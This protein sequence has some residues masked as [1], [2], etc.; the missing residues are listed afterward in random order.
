MPG[1]MLSLWPSR[2][3]TP[4][5]GYGSVDARVRAFLWERE[6]GTHR[7]VV[8][9]AAGM[10]LDRT[11]VAEFQFNAGG[12]E[13]TTP[14]GEQWTVTPLPGCTTCGGG[15]S[16]GIAHQLMRGQGDE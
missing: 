7:F 5:A 2:V 1:E 13:I 15:N 12:V 6:D 8:I 3:E 9:S 4:D 16:A 11:D 14:A 10:I